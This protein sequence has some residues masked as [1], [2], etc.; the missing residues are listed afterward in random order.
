MKIEIQIKGERTEAQGPEARNV[1]RS[2]L[3]EIGQSVLLPLPEVSRTVRRRAI[4]TL[5]AGRP[6]WN[7]LDADGHPHADATIILIPRQ[8]IGIINEDG[9]YEAVGDGPKENPFEKP[10]DVQV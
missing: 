4:D 2:V 5:R 9:T 3:K 1:V 7:K 6:I 8:I 10:D